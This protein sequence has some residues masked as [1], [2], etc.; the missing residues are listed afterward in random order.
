LKSPL[1]ITGLFCASYAA[2]SAASRS[3]L[4]LFKGLFAALPP[5]IAA[6]LM[7]AASYA[8][9]SLSVGSSS[10]WLLLVAGA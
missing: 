1:E 5:P 2:F 3:A 8:I 10:S 7:R 6:K 4:I 9:V